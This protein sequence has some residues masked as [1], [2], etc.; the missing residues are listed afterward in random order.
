MTESAHTP[1]PT[2]PGIPATVAVALIQIYQKTLSPALPAILGP[3][4]GCRFY[5]SCSHYAAEAIGVHGTIRGGW[6]AAK[7][8][9]KCSPLHSGGHDPVPRDNR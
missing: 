8:I 9:I 5:P 7:R 1:L 6:L 4:C 3:S 2:G